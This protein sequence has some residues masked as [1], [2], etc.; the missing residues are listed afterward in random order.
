MILVKSRYVIRLQDIERPKLIYSPLR[1]GLYIG[2][3]VLLGISMAVGLPASPDPFG[4]QLFGTLFIILLMIF[5]LSIGAYARTWHFDKQSKTVTVSRSAAG[6]VYQ[7]EQ[8]PLASLREVCVESARLLPDSAVPGGNRGRVRFSY[9]DKRKFYYSLILYVAER[10]IKVDDGTD[11]G[12]MQQLGEV[13][14]HALGVPFRVR[15]I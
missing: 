14:A 4:D 2:I 7:Q 3:G 8:F 9:A 6:I 13:L 10:R 15:E 5:S 12:H 11:G 1:R